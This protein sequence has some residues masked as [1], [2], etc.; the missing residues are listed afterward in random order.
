MADSYLTWKAIHILGAV[1][2]VGNVTVTGAWTVL[3]WRRRTERTT[4]EIARGIL[5][6]DLL[7][8]LPGGVLMTIGG[9]QMIRIAGLPWTELAW[10]RQ[11]IGL[12]A[13]SSGIWLV[14]LLPDQLRMERCAASDPE[15]FGRLFRRWMILGWLATLL[16]YAGLWIMVRKPGGG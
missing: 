5:W 3:L 1:L 12:L 11:G 2:M 13:A 8:T 14:L 10:L 15:R 16:L 4:V 6:T 7:F 9:I